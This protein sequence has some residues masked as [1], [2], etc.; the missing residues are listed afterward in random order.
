M[1]GVT[2][3]DFFTWL[4]AN[5]ADIASAIQKLIALI[6]QYFSGADVL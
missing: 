5:F 4:L 2:M 1:K 6:V 3:E